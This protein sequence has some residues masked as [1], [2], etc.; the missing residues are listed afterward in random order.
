MANKSAAPMRLSKEAQK[1]FIAYAKKLLTVHQR[2]TEVR[3]K[4][5]LIDIAYARYKLAA[6]EEERRAAGA[7]VC[8][9]LGRDEVTPPIVVSQVD[10]MVAYWADVFLSGYPLFPV[11][12]LPKNRKW[13]EQL[14]G[15]LDDH[16]TLGGYARQLLLFLIDGAKY[17]LCAVEADWDQVPQFTVLADYM[18]EEGQRLQRDAK[19]YTKLRRLDP[20]NIVYDPTVLPGDI[21]AEGDYAGYLS[22]ESRTKLKR[23]LNRYSQAKEVYNASEALNMQQ[24]SPSAYGN[25]YTIAP[26]VSDYV[27]ARRPLDE[28]DWGPWFG[29]NSAAKNRANIGRADNYEIFTFYARII[30]SE[31][32]IDAPQPNTHQIWKC[33]LVNNE[34]LV[35]AKRVVTA[36]DS[37]PIFFG[38]PIEDGLGYQTESIAEGAIE[39]QEAAKTLYNIR[40]AAARRAVSD[41]AIY[42]ADIIN[43]AHINSKAAAPKIPVNLKGI[44]NKTLAD[45]YHQI[46][47]DMRGTES[48]LQD[49]AVI[50]EFAKELRGLNNAQRGQFQKGNKSVTEWQDVMGNS[51]NRLRLSA[52][53][54]EHQ[55]FMPLKETLK[56]NIF[57]F[58]GDAIVVSQKTG[59][60]LEVNI[61]E[62]RKHVMSFR[63]SDGYSPK[64]KLASVDM[65]T[66]G[67]QI[68]GTSELLQQ[69]FGRALP[70]IF[71]HLMQLGG[72]RGLEQYLEE[73]VAA[74]A[75]TAPL[76]QPV[77]VAGTEPVAST[78][79][80]GQQ[81]MDPAMQAMMAGMPGQVPM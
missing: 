32:G 80:Q 59:E 74:T 34:V 44:Q 10:S 76:G 81:T 71:A 14:E 56:L 61:A 1:N 12:S 42:D 25:Y 38:Q 40:F 2:Q 36:Y 39:F 26:Q 9:V 72:V 64:S 47:F 17:N 49:A 52:L 41:R 11:V 33:V 46:P 78:E 3:T 21:A 7:Q 58:G 18:S 24:G 23:R 75:V 66:S 70:N 77:P 20:Y 37:L 4:M 48:T 50:T 22:L 43:P 6:S 53:C 31:F 15:L 16:A 45:A 60:V 5:E 19:Y 54:L 67:M 63:L 62:L 30:P 35:H 55:V 69:S 68:I 13:A 27:S 73:P 65:L 8:D 29:Q 28:V 57:Q 51:D 79:Q